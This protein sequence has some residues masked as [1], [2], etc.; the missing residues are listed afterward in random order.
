[1]CFSWGPVERFSRQEN[2]PYAA[3]A[4]GRPLFVLLQK[5]L[6]AS[7]PSPA[8]RANSYGRGE[9]PAQPLFHSVPLVMRFPQSFTCWARSEEWRAQE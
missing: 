4:S 3:T 6:M 8:L 5:G 1:M 9:A 7:R 2:G